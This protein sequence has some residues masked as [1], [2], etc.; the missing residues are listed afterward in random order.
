MKKKM[1]TDNYIITPQVNMYSY[2]YMNKFSDIFI[3]VNIG[4]L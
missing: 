2:I 1:K 4:L 3:S